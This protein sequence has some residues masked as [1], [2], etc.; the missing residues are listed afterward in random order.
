MAALKRRLNAEAKLLAATALLPR[1]ATADETF[2][3]E[4]LLHAQL[5]STRHKLERLQAR[6]GGAL[7][8]R[9]EVADLLSTDEQG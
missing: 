6:R 1:D 7:V 2:K 9:P 3:Y 5:N 8:P 4:R